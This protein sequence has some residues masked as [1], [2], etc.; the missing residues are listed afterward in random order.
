MTAVGGHHATFVPADFSA[1]FVDVI[2]LGMAD[3]S[4][5]KYINKMETGGDLESIKNLALRRNDRFHF[6]EREYDDVNLDLLPMPARHLTL[7]YRKKYHDAMRNKTASLLTSRGCPYRC[8][9][10]ACWKLMN[11]RYRV[12]SPESVVEEFNSLPEEVNLVCFADDNTLHNIKHA[13]RLSELLKERS[14]KKKFSMYARADTVV[15]NPKLI[16][17]FRES[18]LEYVLVGF[19]SFKEDDLVLLNKR[20]T[21][22]INNEAIQIL[23]KLGV[24]ISAHF[25]I[26]PDYSKKD[27]KQLYK[28][29]CDRN[30]YRL[31]FPILTPLPGTEFYLNNYDRFVIRNYDF[32]DFVHS[33]LPTKLERKEFYRRVSNLYRK[34]YS[35]YRYFKSKMKNFRS[36]FGK[37]NDDVSFNVD[38]NSFFRLI[39]A[40]IFGYPIYLKIKRNYKSEPLL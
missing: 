8:T 37:S 31:A 39:L 16:E 36:L 30:L 7:H 23:Q 12:R 13:W 17:N 2:F 29:V 18:G 5:R 33:I 35:F 11:G 28:Y 24:S 6:T 14:I 40:W 1:P 20:T 38:S 4:F 22:K 19:E 3:S 21:V 27:F 9:F 15:K 32:F 34:S 25:I 26:N 10:C